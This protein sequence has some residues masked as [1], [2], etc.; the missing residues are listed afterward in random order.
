MARGEESLQREL[1]QGLILYPSL[2]ILNPSSS[3]F[4]FLGL[5]WPG[6][7]PLTLAH[8]LRVMRVFNT[9]NEPIWIKAEHAASPL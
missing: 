5:P 7:L 9:S 8:N 2:A 4:V 6:G 1:E 3:S